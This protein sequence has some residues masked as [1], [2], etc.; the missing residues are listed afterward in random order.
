[1]EPIQIEQ[2]AAAALAGQALLTRHLAL[3]FLRETK[4]FSDVP[5]PTVTEPDI[6][7]ATA[8]FVEL[9]AQRRGQQPP[10]W[11]A[12]IERHDEP[13]FLFRCKPESNT[14]RLCLETAPQPLGQRGFYAPYNYLTFV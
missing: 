6:L 9:F 3:T 11:T 8:A 2:V 10:T 7:A 12:E 13:I 1:M 4:N 14:Y 5:P